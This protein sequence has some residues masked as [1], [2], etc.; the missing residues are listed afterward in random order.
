MWR[1]SFSQSALSLSRN[2]M[3]HG[4]SESLRRKSILK[5]VP[6]LVKHYVFQLRLSCVFPNAGCQGIC[7]N[8]FLW[9]SFERLRLFY[10]RS[11]EIVI[12]FL[13]LDDSGSA[14]S[15]VERTALGSDTVKQTSS[16]SQQNKLLPDSHLTSCVS[17]C[18]NLC[19]CNIF[20]SVVYLNG[21]WR[22][23]KLNCA[24]EGIWFLQSTILSGGIRL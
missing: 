22:N 7:W 8:L 2:M 9:L 19:G 10:W 12:E 3:I 20:N 6:V 17:I 14:A 4:D 5:L 11:A 18:M 1:P 16:V 24:L 13:S 21:L 23:R 15:A